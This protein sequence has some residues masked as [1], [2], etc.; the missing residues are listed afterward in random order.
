M[1]TRA[2]RSRPTMATAPVESCVSIASP[3]TSRGRGPRSGRSPSCPTTSR[4]GWRRGAD[5]GEEHRRGFRARTSPRNL[6]L[7]LLRLL[8]LRLPA[9]VVIAQSSGEIGFVREFGEPDK[10]G[11]MRARF[12]RLGGGL[13]WLQLTD[14]YKSVAAARNSPHTPDDYMLLAFAP[15]GDDHGLRLVGTQAETHFDKDL[16]TAEWTYQK[17]DD[18]VAFSI[19]SGNGLVLEK[20]LR[21]DPAQRGF[22]LEL[23]LH[24]K[25][26][27]PGGQV[28]FTLLGP[29]LVNPS[30][31]S[32]LGT[33]SVAIA[34]SG[35]GAP[36]HVGPAP[37]KVQPLDVDLKNLSFAGNTNR[38]F[39]AFLYPRDDASRAALVRVA[40]DT[41]PARMDPASE[42]PPNSVA[43]ALYSMSLAIPARDAETRVSFGL[44]LG[45]KS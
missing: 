23:V 29:A 6:M 13:V 20:N 45:P 30:E 4:R 24:N 22:V 31:V 2:S 8:F 26:A 16:A 33:S 11:S 15:N 39:G 44:Y 41:V 38:F 35:D 5:R 7:K 37:G 43:R 36:K 25:S 42:T 18:G 34:D 10:P 3:T 40:V 19:E 17:R 14:H 27:E 1:A 9:S 28:V 12:S 32:L 21:H